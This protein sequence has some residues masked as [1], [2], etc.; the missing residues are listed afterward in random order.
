M[1]EK[2]EKNEARGLEERM[3]LFILKK[4]SNSFFNYISRYLSFSILDFSLTKDEECVQGIKRLL[5]GVIKIS[6]M[7]FIQIPL[8]I[9]I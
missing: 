4:I 2:V 6:K 7:I 9:R 1:I 8:Q 5:E 3:V